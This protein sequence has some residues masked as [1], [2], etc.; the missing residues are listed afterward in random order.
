MWNE[1]ATLTRTRW[2]HCTT[3]GCLSLERAMCI[4]TY[5]GDGEKRK[6]FS[7]AYAARQLI[8]HLPRPA[9]KQFWRNVD[10][11]PENQFDDVYFAL[12]AHSQR[13]TDIVGCNVHS[14]KHKRDNWQAAWVCDILCYT[15]ICNNRNEISISSMMI[16]YG[17]EIIKK[18]SVKIECLPCVN[19]IAFTFNGP[20]P[21]TY[22]ICTFAPLTY[23]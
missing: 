21:G 13:R 3:V 4:H 18:Y 20:S 1:I 9:H 8:S 16:F 7:Y 14:V 23:M 5:V 12:Y 19:V 11:L 15:L 17:N 22:F 2:R 10:L 6:L